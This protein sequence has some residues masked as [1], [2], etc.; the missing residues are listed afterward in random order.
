MRERGRLVF[1]MDGDRGEDTE[2]FI[3]NALKH[4][5]IIKWAY[6]LH[7]KDVCNE[8]DLGSWRYGLSY[9]LAD[10]YD[11]SE[12]YSSTEEYYEEEM[13]H[14]PFV[15]GDKKKPQ[16]VVFFT[17]DKSCK[18]LEAASWFGLD[19]GNIQGVAYREDIADQ[20]KKLTQEDKFS[21]GFERH[22]YC[23]EEVKANFDFRD[24]INRTES[25]NTI[26]KK[27]RKIRDLLIPTYLME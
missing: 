7:D 14:C 26:V 5:K 9:A 16:W 21:I 25:V 13:K 6:I 12:K 4:E 23:D 10:G 18:L 22:R 24:Y 19:D 2:G 20:I 8:H 15:V 11:W 1:I 3:R 17:T 27:L